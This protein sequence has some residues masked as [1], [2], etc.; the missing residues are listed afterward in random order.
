MG[1]IASLES[2]GDKSEVNQ[3]PDEFNVKPSQ[4]VRI[5]H[6]WKIYAAFISLGMCSALIS[7]YQK[8]FAQQYIQDDAFLALVA[9]VQ[10]FVNGTCRIF[11]GFIFDKTGFQVNIIVCFILAIEHSSIQ[12]CSW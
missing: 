1:E 11:W 7:N 5:F 2:E 4:V 8:T 6:F 9:T 12:I 10:N 3:Q